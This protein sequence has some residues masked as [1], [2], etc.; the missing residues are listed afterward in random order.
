LPVHLSIKNYGTS[1]HEKYVREKAALLEAK[2]VRFLEREG[3]TGWSIRVLNETH[4]DA[5]A[6]REIEDGIEEAISRSMAEN[7][8]V[9]VGNRW[10]LRAQIISE[11]FGPFSRNYISYQFILVAPHHENE[12][13]NMMSKLEEGCTNFRK[14][15]D[16]EQGDVARAIIIRLSPSASTDLCAE[17]AREYFAT[18][19]EV[20]DGIILYQPATVMNG[21]TIALAHHFIQVSNPK[22][23]GRPSGAAFAALRGSVYVGDIVS[24]P[25]ELFLTDGGVKIPLRGRYAYQRGDIYTLFKKEPGDVR[26]LAPGVRQYAVVERDGVEHLIQGS[27]PPTHELLLLP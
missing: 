3:K 13:K 12:S 25:V 1:E 8:A 7:A 17:W 21:E 26:L 23:E 9:P 24:Q 5:E 27:F 19:D 18:S 10:N 6:W 11:E 16:N 20:L 2:V 4:P 22:T 15:R 14:H